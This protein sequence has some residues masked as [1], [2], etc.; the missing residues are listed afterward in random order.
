MAGLQL[1]AAG[2]GS[3]VAA[4]GEGALDDHVAGALDEERHEV[5]DVTDVPDPRY[6]VTLEQKRRWDVAEDLAEAM[7]AY[8]HPGER[9]AAVLGAIRAFYHSGIPTDPHRSGA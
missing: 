7:F 1:Q 3:R 2:P 4:V 5:A 8:L 9:R 6:V